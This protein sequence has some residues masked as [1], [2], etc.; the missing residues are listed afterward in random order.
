VGGSRRSG[1]L[2]LVS[3]VLL[4]VNLRAAVTALSPLLPRVTHDTGLTSAQVGLLGALPPFC[5]AASALLGPALLR[6]A[7]AERLVL[8]AL[9]LTALGQAVRPWAPGVV[10]FL[11]ATVVAL[12]GMGTGNVVLP[13]LV[14]TYFPGR[15]GQVTAVYVTALTLGT[16]LPSL[17]AVPLAD[18][19]S[20]WTGSAGAGWQLALAAWSG[21]ALLALVSWLRPAAHPCAVPGTREARAARLAVHR[22]RVAWGVMLVFGVNS[23]VSYAL[24]AWLP[25]RL[26]EA[27]LTDDVAGQALALY[28]GV[29]IPSSLVVPVLAARLRWQFP[30]VVVFAACF[31]AGLLGLL[32]APT[33]L[34]MLWALVAGAGGSGFPLALTLIGLRTRTPSSAGALSGFV[35][36]FGYLGAGL[37]PLTVGVLRQETGG[38]VA[39]F[40]VLGVALLLSLLGGALA[41]RPRTVEDDLAA[42]RGIPVVHPDTLT[43]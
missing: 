43:G 30:L 28:A 15:I 37:G 10:G 9:G 29:G 6:R 16:A 7:S 31:A 25:L 2:L 19:I 12:L 35:Q 3:V 4:A 41:G 27:G 18:T 26:V 20:G 42:A 39:P 13:V 8:L 40:G 14:K 21:T 5:F 22:S 33:R 32:V 17:V 24:F 23:L 34:T 36:G 1:L 38:W 11:L